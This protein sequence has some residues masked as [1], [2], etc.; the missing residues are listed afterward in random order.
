MYALWSPVP[1]PFPVQRIAFVIAMQ[2]VKYSIEGDVL[3]VRLFVILSLILWGNPIFT[4]DFSTLAVKEKGIYLDIY[5]NDERVLSKP[6]GFVFSFGVNKNHIY[7]TGGDASKGS[8]VWIRSWN[9]KTGEPGFSTPI[10]EHVTGYLQGPIE[11]ILFDNDTGIG[12][13]VSLDIS[14]TPQ[15]ILNVFDSE[16]GTL[17][18]YKIP[19]KGC[20]PTIGKTS[21]GIIVYHETIKNLF[22]FDIENKR[23]SVYSFEQESQKG[24]VTFS[25]LG[26]FLNSSK[27]GMVNLSNSNQVAKKVFPLQG[28][29]FSSRVGSVMVHN[30]IALWLGQKN[31]QTFLSV[32]D[33]QKN[34]I[35]IQNVQL[36]FSPRGILTWSYQGLNFFDHEHK[37][38]VTLDLTNSQEL[39]RQFV[40][41]DT[42]H[43]I[44]YSEH[45]R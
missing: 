7:T 15:A 9:F 32:L 14:N 31:E 4:G 29:A 36:N 44:W 39:G 6:L 34:T 38:I 11:Q 37:E 8:Q 21:N 19:F 1:V 18:K 25:H 42:L 43:L 2:I 22:L 27:D 23:F 17:E 45:I 13:F 33:N 20:L 10:R 24:F 30:E 28:E 40:E 26:V 12:A 5:K 3:M 16:T 41:T 35:G